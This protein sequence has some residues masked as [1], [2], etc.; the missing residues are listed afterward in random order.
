MATAVAP[1]ATPKTTTSVDPL[2]S[3]AVA[4]AKA[5]LG[6]EAAPIQGQQAASDAQYKTAEGDATNVA[7]ALSDLLKGIAPDV[8]KT[9]TTAAQNDELAASGFSAG[10]QD[11]LKGNTDNLNAML[12]K[13]GQPVTLDSHAGQAGDVAYGLGGYNPGTSLEQQGA[14]FGAAAKLLPGD[15]L[16]QGQE[17]V[18]SLQGKALLADQDFANKLAAVAAKLPGDVQT[19]YQKLQTLALANKKFALSV[20]KEKFDESAK[21]ASQKLAVAKYNTGI[22]EFDARQKMAAQRLANSQFNADRNYQLSLS[23][24]GIE[25]RRLQL[26][27]AQNAFKAANG[28]Y[29]SKEMGKIQVQAM[30]LAHSYFEGSSTTKGYSTS[31]TTT[32]KA[33]TS[34]TRLSQTNTQ[35]IPYQ[36]A[37]SKMMQK[38]IPVQIALRALNSVYPPAQQL[39]ASGLE[40]Y[41]GPLTPANIAAASAQLHAAGGGALADTAGYGLNPYVVDT[42]SMKNLS[43]QGKQVVGGVMALA[44]Q[45]LGAP[46]LW[47]GESP[48]GFDCSGLAQ[49]IYAKEGITIPR[50]TFEQFQ[51]G[52]SVPSN[53]LQAGDLVFFKGSDSQN[54]LPGHVGIYIGSG[55]FIEAPH[56]G[57]VVRVSNL[58]GYPGYVGARRY[59]R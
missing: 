50:T 31:S 54:G 52:L 56:T 33:G 17:N 46:Y 57:A 51:T 27:I 21:I 42:A 2:Y 10:M 7:S 12:A 36:A 23:R 55:K 16:L 22:A 18:K 58:R 49:F 38:G 45:Y 30:G 43:A 48:K 35:G 11:A 5:A 53:Q 44:Q 24:L 15:A 8:Q 3:Q 39:N 41:L 13:L 29:S 9:Y 25:N 20:Q 32:G 37:L 1:P 4:Q 6:A 28:G 34:S 40:S 59:V 26:T 19:N 14:A 47:G